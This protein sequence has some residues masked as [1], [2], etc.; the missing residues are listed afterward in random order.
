M[1][2]KIYN[3]DLTLNLI[4]NGDK[5]QPGNK[6]LLQEL[7][8]LDDATRR[9]QLRNAALELEKR[10]LNRTS[11]NYAS[12]LK[13]IDM[14]MRANNQ[15]ID[16]FHARMMQLRGQIGITGLTINQLNTHLRILQ[17]ML[18]NATS[19]TTITQLQQQIA[20]VQVRI[21][22]LT[23]GASRLSIAWSNMARTINKYSAA[24]GWLSIAVY[25]VSSTIGGMINRVSD[26][27][28]TLSNVMK[29]TG[30]TRAEMYRLKHEFDI[31]PTPT[32]TD[33]LLKMA[34]IAGKLGIN[35]YDNIRKFT[36]SV[37]VL[38]TAL[39]A[40]LNLSVEEV[41]NSVGKLV[42]AF[43]VTDKMPIDEALLR[44]GSLLNELDKSSVA[45]AGTILNYLTRL[46]SLGTAANYPI[47][48][49]AGL[50]AAMESVNIPAERGGTALMNIISGLGKNSEKFSR[51]LGMRL[52]D[53]KK[54]VE[55]DING[56]FLKLIELTTK[57]DKSIIDM[58]ESMGTFELSGVRVRETYQAIAQN[59]DVIR[60]QQDIA[61]E[62]FKSSASVMAEF[63]IISK[64][65]QGNLDLQKK[66]VTALADEY[67]LKLAP[68]GY[69]LF[70][71]WVDFLYLLRDLAKGLYEHQNIIYGLAF[72]YIAL[73]ATAI[74]AW[75][76][77]AT[78]ATTAYIAASK[79]N[80]RAI[81]AQSAALQM[82]KNH[83]IA[84]LI[85]AIRLLWAALLANPWGP[86]LAIVSI[87]TGAFFL[88]A[89]KIDLVKEATIDLQA[90]LIKN[91]RSLK[92]VFDA[93]VN[94]ANGT[95]KHKAAIRAINE[96]YGKYLPKLLTEADN[97]NTV[98]TARNLAIKALREEISLKWE[99]ERVSKIQ[100]D[101]IEKRKSSYQKILDGLKPEELGVASRALDDM[102]MKILSNKEVGKNSAELLGNRYVDEIF[103][104]YSSTPDGEYQEWL[105]NRKGKMEKYI[106]VL[107][108]EKQQMASLNKFTEGYHAADAAKK[109][110]GNSGNNI[111]GDG[112]LPMTEENYKLQKAGIERANKERTV[113]LNS[114][115]KNET[116]FKADSLKQQ[117]EYTNAMIGLEEKYAAQD[118]TVL[119]DLKVKRSEIQREMYTNSV[120]L[121]KDEK[122][123]DAQFDKD[124][125]D[126]IKQRVE[127]ESDIYDRLE[128]EHKLAFT[129]GEMDEKSYNQQILGLEL[130][131]WKSIQ[132]IQDQGG[133]DSSETQ[134]KVADAE[135]AIRK[136]NIEDM[137]AAA[138]EWFVNEKLRI[139]KEYG[140]D[141][142]KK[143]NYN[144]Q[145]LLMEIGYQTA[146]LD[147]RKAAGEQTADIELKLFELRKGLMNEGIKDA[148]KTESDLNKI[149]GKRNGYLSKYHALSKEI[150]KTNAD[151]TKTDEQKKAKVG[152]LTEAQKELTEAEAIRVA[153]SITADIDQANSTQEATVAILNGIR[154]R[155]EAYAAEAIA[156]SIVAS[157]GDGIFGIIAATA[158]AAAFALLFNTIV[159]KFSVNSESGKV[160]GK[161]LGQHYS[162]KYPVTGASDGRSYM[163]SW[164]GEAKTGIYG[165]PALIAERGPEMVVDYPTLRNMQMNAPG[166]IRAIM[167]MRVPQYGN[168]KYKGITGR[169]GDGEQ[170]NNNSGP[171][172]QNGDGLYQA[173]ENMNTTVS[174]LNQSIANGITARVAGYGGEG[175]V[176]DAIQKIAALAKSLKL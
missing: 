53:Y 24:V 85:P 108:E 46:S 4:L 142:N 5:L 93:A 55:T 116:Q 119:D 41:A 95:D 153:A 71:L 68:A 125:I 13:R 113:A 137:E 94:S 14:A 50:A 151:S 144:H 87:V 76:K 57:G 27:D 22:Q 175:S 145:L 16:A 167:A 147:I 133:V 134:Q 166:L 44:T 82:L 130:E 171:V 135:L 9:L 122:K 164:A 74:V 126:L 143:E 127:A 79:N 3:E 29:T 90:E 37:D 146:L 103:K 51:I 17:T 88:L 173:I 75:I 45:S 136:G 121:K 128:A 80:I 156:K 123:D 96:Q 30:L 26:L 112:T 154:S 141:I 120:N 111:G 58:T 47:E 174:K 60:T 131:K 64:D 11:A 176:A 91:M 36:L 18:R 105:V 69:T 32:K 158:A 109:V 34:E 162:G 99:N 73:K 56:V 10:G 38:N 101:F 170:W 49:L 102:T 100:E 39:K 23:T 86:I 62:A 107:M 84:G 165:T 163:A 2:K 19:P 61:T 35:G 8:Q 132:A 40:D 81:I 92:A 115:K 31:A 65:F 20:Q 148:D 66:R 149:Y 160:E 54:A 6:K 152:D 118:A 42:N 124:K 72:A 172:T 139:E 114:S 78:A 106:S 169:W 157:A 83:G 15:A 52:E 117:L 150:D 7:Y 104:K 48:K 97:I 140:G 168:G 70:K 110:A 59:L 33:D 21:Q 67:N 43:R 63:N 159:P 28:R 138:E 1:N 98:T 129:R 89:G 25:A 161:G 12:E 77:S 155:I